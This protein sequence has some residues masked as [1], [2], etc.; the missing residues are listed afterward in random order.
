[1]YLPSWDALAIQATHRPLSCRVAHFSCPLWALRQDKSSKPPHR[2]LSSA[3]A[4]PPTVQQSTGAGLVQCLLFLVRPPLGI[5]AH[6]RH[7]PPTSPFTDQSHSLK[8]FYLLLP[9]S[10]NFDPFDPIDSPFPR[11][12][13]QRL[14]TLPFCEGDLS[15]CH[16][17]CLANLVS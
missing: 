12:L 1:M 13:H 4:E 9:H 6:A 16:F 3:S 8:P 7:Q 14:S 15:L 17:G 2:S 10:T 5:L 11:P